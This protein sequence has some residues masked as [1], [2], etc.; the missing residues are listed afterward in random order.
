MIEAESPPSLSETSRSLSAGT[1]RRSTA[2]TLE[3]APVG[4]LCERGTERGISDLWNSSCLPD[5]PSS[6]C[7]CMGMGA[8]A[9]LMGAPGAS[10]GS[11]W[12]CMKPRMDDV[13]AGGTGRAMGSWFEMEPRRCATT[14]CSH[15]VAAAVGACG[16]AR[17]MLLSVVRRGCDDAAGGLAASDQLRGGLGFICGAAKA[18]LGVAVAARVSQGGEARCEPSRTGG[19]MR[20]PRGS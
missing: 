10:A 5:G 20:E 19:D 7:M 11:L 1:A 17:L 4:P 8:A 2:G 18:L 9:G 12:C 14:G 15:S 3:A 16:G 13:G 6:V